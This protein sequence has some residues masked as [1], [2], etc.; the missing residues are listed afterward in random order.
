MPAFNYNLTWEDPKLTYEPNPDVGGFALAGINSHDWPVDF[1]TISA[2]PVS[3]R[4]TLVFNFYTKN[5]WN[6]SRLG[7]L[8]YQDV[9][10][11]AYDE[12][13]N[14]G[15]ITGIKILQKAII[16]CGSTIGIDGD[17]GPLTMEAANSL[18]DDQLLAALR[19]QRLAYYKK[20]VDNN[21]LDIKYFANWKE[22]A[23]A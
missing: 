16:S 12:C 15:L 2:V 1:A 13:V 19:S 4:P 17:F 6:P 8:Y 7:G 21:E 11:R 20:I 5:Y 3:Q 18:D 9:T 10:S 23:L 22:R 14:A